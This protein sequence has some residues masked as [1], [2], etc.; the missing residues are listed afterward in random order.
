MSAYYLLLTL[1][2]ANASAAEPPPVANLK[3]RVNLAAF[4]FF[5]KTAHHV[6]DIEVPKIT[7]P[8]ITCNITAG[9][10]RGTASVYKLN[11]KKFR[12]PKFD[13]LLSDDGLSWSSSQGAIKIGGLWEAEY[14]FL[15]PFYES[16]WIEALAADIHIKVSARVIVVN[17]RPQII[18]NHCA[19]DVTHFDVEIG[20]GVLPWLVNLF[21]EII[22]I[23][24]RKAIHN[25]ACETARSVLVGKFNDFL[26]T[27]PLR[28]PVGKGFYVNYAFE[29]DPVFS[30]S[31]VEG[32]ATAEVLYGMRSC[33]PAM[34]D[35]WSEKSLLP[36]MMV[37]WMS[38]SV[39]NC[40]L[41]TAHAGELI[42][43]TATKNVPKL[44]PYLR[45][46]CSLLSICIGRFFSK[47]SREYPD[48]YIDLH[49]HTFDS[50]TVRME[51]GGVNASAT[52]AVDFYIHPKKLHQVNLARIILELSS[53]VVPEIRENRFVGR[54]NGSE[55]D[56]REDF[57]NI[58]KMSRTFLAMFKEVFAMTAH[59]MMQ[60]I[61]HKGV[62]FPVFDNITVSNSSELRVFKKYI[63]LDADFEFN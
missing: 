25:Q 4:K 17:N 30:S 28:L 44:A 29:G 19:A 15:I 63:R 49:F 37:V 57:S 16:G 8:V 5:S 34:T 53:S 23:E 27:L 54:L 56:V 26:L 33:T 13:F 38:E 1:F 7:L 21:Q 59:V 60:A 45:T 55:I 62:P 3:A 61:L 40:L 12:S 11:V 58:G 51:S 2:I 35:E 10:G 43:F 14:T 20:G 9:P 46:S 50:P 41:S 48:Q 18:L 52:F 24:V 36:R 32:V 6:V 39:P 42:Q 22:S 47:L 31:F